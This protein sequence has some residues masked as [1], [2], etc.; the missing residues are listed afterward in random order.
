MTPKLGGKR[1]ERKTLWS[2][3]ARRR[4]DLINCTAQDF[5]RRWMNDNHSRAGWMSAATPEECLDA[6][7][8]PKLATER[9]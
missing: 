6:T 8:D 1:R 3:S 7:V 4:F 5:L 2:V 9:R